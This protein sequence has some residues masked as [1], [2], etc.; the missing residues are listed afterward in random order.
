MTE[1]ARGS[2]GAAPRRRGSLFRHVA[3]LL[4]FAA[5][6]LAC[7]PDDA[8]A[9]RHELD[10]GRTAAAARPWEHERSD[11][12][13]DPRLH[14]GSLEN[15][16]RWAW[17]ETTRFGWIHMS[18]VVNVGSLAE[19]DDDLG[20]AH[21]VE[22]M[23]FNGTENH[24]PGTLVERFQSWGAE[25]GPDLNATTTE[26]VTRYWFALPARE[27]LEFGVQLLRDFA[28][29]QSLLTAEVEA[30][31]AVIDSEQRERD[32]PEDRC[33]ERV[34]RE[35]YP[36]ARLTHRPPIGVREVRSRFTPEALRAFL[37]K[38]YRPEN[39][40]LIIAG[41]LGGLDP[42]A[43]IRSTFA[44]VPRSEEPLVVQPG[45]GAALPEVA[46]AGFFEPG[47]GYTWLQIS[48]RR[49]PVE[50]RYDR[51]HLEQECLLD[52]ARL[53]LEQR[54]SA[55]SR[56]PAPPFFQVEVCAHDGSGMNV[57]EDV[58]LGCVPERWREA[59]AAGEQELR[60]VLEQGFTEGELEPV[61]ADL[62][63]E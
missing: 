16:L 25:F 21:F 26:H 8:P 44:A 9:E 52:T 47:M 6:A 28:F 31:K 57:G 37:R 32:G 19:A 38:W 46:S 33:L 29:G 10:S 30:E 7:G 62:L 59:L 48:N 1:P 17:A 5:S 11:L 20:M 51:A 36:D 49:L 14:F 2:P 13:P 24:P 60:N 4:L 45:A 63:R 18:L 39:M 53:M 58:I 61:R 27:G 22:H 35:L 42:D 15:G 56:A 50:V 34:Q 54:L 41:R 23:A 3:R 40:T 55:R 12:A 43:T